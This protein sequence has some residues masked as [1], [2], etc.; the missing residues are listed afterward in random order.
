MKK[1]TYNNELLKV[2]GI[3]TSVL[4]N[5]VNGKRKEFQVFLNNVSLK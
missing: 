3:L 5:E 4:K 2:T 1:K